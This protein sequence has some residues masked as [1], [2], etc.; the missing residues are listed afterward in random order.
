[1][2]AKTKP[3]IKPVVRHIDETN[4]ARICHDIEWEIRAYDTYTVG[5]GK[6][7][8]CP[9]CF[10]T[11]TTTV[12]CDDGEKRAFIYCYQ[13]QIGRICVIARERKY[14]ERVIKEMHYTCDDMGCTMYCG[15]AN[16][17]YEY[18]FLRKMFKDLIGSTPDNRPQIL[19]DVCKPLSVSV[20][21]VIMVDICNMTNSSLAKIGK[22]YCTTQ[23][24]VGDLDYSV[25]R[26]S[27]TP[28][29][30]EEL[31][32]CIN[33]VV[34]GAEYM[35]YMHSKYTKEGDRMPLTATGIPRGI[36]KKGAY[37]THKGKF[38]NKKI[39]DEILNGYPDDYPT[40]ELHMDKL[41][42]GGYTH[43]NIYYAGE[44]LHD[45]EHA[46]YTSDYPACMLQH[47]YPTSFAT[48]ETYKGRAIFAKDFAN[49]K[50]L[51]ALL[52]M[53]DDI[54]FYANVTFENLVTVT[55]HTIESK[56]K[57]I[58]AE[59]LV[60]DNGRV[61]SA[62]KVTVLITEQ[63]YITYKKFY[64]W[65]SLT[66]NEIKIGKK[67][68][69]PEYVIKAVVESYVLKK[70]LKDN[71]LPYAA[72]KGILNSSYG[73]TVQRLNIEDMRE[74]EVDNEIKTIKAPFPFR[75]LDLSV[76]GNLKIFN[77]VVDQ[78]NKK[79]PHTQALCDDIKRIYNDYNNGRGGLWYTSERDQ[80]IATTVKSVLQQEAYDAERLGTFGRSIMLSCYWG[81]WVTAYARRRLTDMIYSLES[82]AIANG[83][84][85]IVVYCDTDSIFVNS[86]QDDDCHAFVSN[87]IK[88]Y[89]NK[90]RINNQN[91]LSKYTNLI[92]AD[93]IQNKA[94]LLNDI[95]EFDY[96]P[97]ASHFK[98]LGAKRYLQRYIPKKK[99]EY[100]IES[101]IAGLG[102]KDFSRKVNSLGG[103]VEDKFNFFTDGMVLTEFETSKLR[104]VYYT[105]PYEA[106]VTDDY[107]NTEIMREDC[108]QVLMNVGF[109]MVLV[110]S[111]AEH[112][113][114]RIG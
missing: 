44:I 80:D 43:G 100:I 96:E 46:D 50:G 27:K 111:I 82:W 66:I 48:S 93:D 72:E 31:G 53:E 11:E 74:I 57:C 51:D 69:L 113:A 90:T 108:G 52:K 110:G 15:I 17:K 75:Y 36:M 107:G 114:K 78:L 76:E 1:M 14:I 3:F 98:Q 109:E 68:P 63:D 65:S 37:K 73:C 84:E 30:A 64:T 101:T 79:Y 55:H 67:K 104:P 49:E 83:Y 42:R 4:Y 13:M 10:D 89:N 87:T 26:N 22:D 8:T 70:W 47:K 40:Y 103:S 18:S 20:G 6:V 77:K 88:A 56:H 21:N 62:D 34:V 92:N 38:V 106:T 16:I 60:E 32:Y 2:K 112:L 95:G 86:N 35:M 99:T 94:E 45:I 29:T 7:S 102:K 91:K 59:G 25:I 58:D 39:L 105:K 33:D 28:L 5:K 9:A 12:T 24:A 23:K 97:T 81:I 41:F 19:L 61:R 71:N 85:D 54:A